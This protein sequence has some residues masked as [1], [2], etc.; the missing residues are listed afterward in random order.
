M[1]ELKQAVADTFFGGF[2]KLEGRIMAMLD[3]KEVAITKLFEY[4]LDAMEV[5]R[6]QKRQVLCRDLILLECLII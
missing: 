5:K 3:A 4:M 6:I 1:R 2:D